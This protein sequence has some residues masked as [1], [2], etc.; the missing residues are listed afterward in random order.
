MRFSY[1]LVSFD[2]DSPQEWVEEVLNERQVRFFE[3]PGIIRRYAVEMAA[4]RA[5]KF[6]AFCESLLGVTRVFRE[7][8]DGPPKRTYRR[9]SLAETK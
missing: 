7:D 3:I 1:I 4:V 2:G 5:D 9:K 6:V 8:Y